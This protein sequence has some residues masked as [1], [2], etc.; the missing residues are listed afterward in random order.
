M[1]YP[2]GE[3]PFGRGRL[4]SETPE[5][6]GGRVDLA[7]ATVFPFDDHAAVGAERPNDTA[8]AC[9]ELRAGVGNELDRSADLHARGDPCREK[10]CSGGVHASHMRQVSGGFIPRTGEGWR[11]T[12]AKRD[13]RRWSGPEFDG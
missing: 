9:V 11:S 13:V 2:L 4:R 6:G 7:I 10:S 1:A 12:T 5:P 8:I 3:A